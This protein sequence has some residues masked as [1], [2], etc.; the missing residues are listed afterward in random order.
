[1]DARLRSSGRSGHPGQSDL[2]ARLTVEIAGNPPEP[3][4]TGWV[5]PDPAEC[6]PDDV[7]AVGADLEPGTLLAA[8]R[9][10]MFPMNLPDGGQ[11]AWWSPWRRGILPIGGIRMTR[12]L[13]RSTRRYRTT[14]DRDF[15][16]VVA[17]CADPHREHGWITD[18]IRSAYIRLHQLGFAHSIETW[19]GTRLVGGLYGVNVG[20]LFAGESMFHRATD[21]SKVA[22]VRLVEIMEATSDSLIDVQWATEHLA[23][24]GAAD[25]SRFRYLELLQNALAAR[26]PREFRWDRAGGAG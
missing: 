1:M 17:G 19:E 11:L 18:D 5:F 10:G 14:V 3:E 7:I 23:S 2:T 12:S 4:I 20:G 15:E 6:G 26:I 21:A 8:Y 22:L 24:L 25:V 13:K 16:G 9:S